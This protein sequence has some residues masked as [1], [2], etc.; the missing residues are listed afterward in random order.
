M[1][2]AIPA[3]VPALLLGLVVLG[4]RQ[5][6]PRVVRPQALVAVALAMFGLSLFGVVSAFGGDPIALLAW[7][8]GYAATLR[9]GARPFGAGRLSAVGTSVHVPGS[10]VPLALILAIFAAKF[11]LGFAAGVHAPWLHQA[12]FVAAMSAVLGALSGGFGARAL[13]VHRC[14]A[15]ARA[16]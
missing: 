9:L 3:W 1:L 12:G 10:W 7:A 14:A 5:S 4:Y 16:A 11:L 15:A 13:A 8:A 2:A 6:Q